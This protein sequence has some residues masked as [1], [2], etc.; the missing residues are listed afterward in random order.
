M[1]LSQLFSRGTAA[2][3]AIGVRCVT[4]YKLKTHKGTAKRWMPVDNGAKFK[5]MKCGKAHLN[6]GLTSSRYSRLSD[7]AYAEGKRT[8]RTLRRLLP[9]V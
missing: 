1:F 7:M 8:M 3:N 6:Y 4:T 5:R 9:Y 2:A